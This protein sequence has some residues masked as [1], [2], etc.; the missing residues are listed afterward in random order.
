MILIFCSVIYA[1]LATLSF[2]QTC[3]C[4]NRVGDGGT[5][6]YNIKGMQP[7]SCGN[8]ASD[9]EMK[10]HTYRRSFN[11]Y[12]NNEMYPMDGVS[13][14]AQFSYF[15]GQSNK[16]LIINDQYPARH[17][18]NVVGHQAE[19]M[20]NYF[21]LT[22]WVTFFAQFV[23]HMLFSTAESE[24]DSERFPIRIDSAD[25]ILCNFSE[26]N[27]PFKRSVRGCVEENQDLERPI[28]SLSSAVDLSGV[29]GSS[30]AASDQLRSK[31]NGRLKSVIEN[32]K[33]YLPRNGDEFSAIKMSFPDGDYKDNFFVAGDHRANENPALASIHTLFVREHNRIANE[34]SGIITQEDIYGYPDFNGDMDEAL[35]QLAKRINEAQFQRIVHEEFIPVLTG[36]ELRVTP[37][38][39]LRHAVSDLFSTC[40]FRVGHSLVGETIELHSGPGLKT[41][42]PLSTLFFKRAD[43]LTSTGIEGFITGAASHRAQEIDTMI[44]NVLRNHLFVNVRGNEMSVDLLAL[45]IQRCRDH[46]LPS[47]NEVREL[48]GLPRV[49]SVSQITRFPDMQEK[50]S[51]AYKTVDKIEAW[52]GLMAEDHPIG[53][54]MGTTL[55]KLWELE[56]K[57]VLGGDRFFYRNS[58]YH[59]LLKSKY[60]AQLNAII[61]GSRSMRGIILDNTDI[62][63]SDLPSNIWRQ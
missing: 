18:S 9:P 10:C 54:A 19:D 21:G 31:T 53:S 24:E 14:T 44:V 27:I 45:N 17:I 1:T 13:R 26:P 7:R 52:V 42:I 35:F 6:N 56:F 62:L 23:D 51:I 58:L 43:L 59:P 39:E 15:E 61:S 47:Y 37:N 22:D 25:P 29:Y 33:E 5:G 38:P 46:G 57:R 48:V 12:C 30:K 8:T 16:D 50:L 3:N 2:S 36:K 40:A 11:G 4:L 60:A 20:P 32:G 41:E 49:T 55:V 63:T 34:L 28:N